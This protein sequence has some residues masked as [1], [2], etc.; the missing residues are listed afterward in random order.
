MSKPYECSRIR[1]AVTAL[2]A[3]LFLA[4]TVHGQIAR[5]GAIGDSLTDEYLEEGGYG[6]GSRSWSELLVQERGISMGPTAAAAGAGYWGEPRRSGYED[7]WA[8]FGITTD[9]SLG[10]GAHTGL[11][12]GV[13]L[14]GVSHAAMFIG[15]ND[16]APWALGTYSNIYWDVWTPAETQ[17]WLDS[18]IANYR[19]FLDTLRPTG[20]RLVLMSVID[21]SAMP[22]IWEGDFPDAARRDRVSTALAAFRDRVRA[23]AD[24][25]DCVFLDMYALTKDIY[26]PN[27]ALR[28]ALL[29]GNVP[30]MLTSRDDGASPATGWVSDGIH[31]NTVV[32]GVWANAV[33][34]ALNFAYDADVSPFSEQELLAH[35]GLSYGGSDTLG[36]VIPSFGPYIYNFAPAFCPGDA[37]G[38]R[39]V[40]FSDITATLNAWGANYF[41]GTSGGLGDSNGDASVDFADITRILTTWGATC[42]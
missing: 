1:C 41:P 22:Y 28:A 32:Q 20:V 14:R 15:G 19:V 6:S 23:L 11:A 31:P 26:G 33:I 3:A 25:Y 34:A 4:S 35:D 21:F 9:G 29:I 10:A 7:N 5:L 18:R 2:G 38:N 12:S 39:A 30:I 37:D 8:R 16:F 27:S 42:D 36:A 13:T 40:S 24:E 17:N